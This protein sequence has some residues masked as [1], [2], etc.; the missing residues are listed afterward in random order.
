MIQQ[1]RISTSQPDSLTS[2]A[3]DWPTPSSHDSDDR[4]R[5]RR[6]RRSSSGTDHQCSQVRPIGKTNWFT[7][8]LEGRDPAPYQEAPR[9]AAREIQEAVRNENWNANGGYQGICRRAFGE[10]KE[11]WTKIDNK[12]LSELKR[13]NNWP[14][15]KEYF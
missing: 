4:P 14:W 10:M 5:T 15:R 8:L 13:S 6:V 7:V 1:A 11:S 12:N 3:R 2:K 9:D